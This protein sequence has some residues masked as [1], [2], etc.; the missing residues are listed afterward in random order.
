MTLE[1]KRNDCCVPHRGGGVRSPGI[2]AT[3]LSLVLCHLYLGEGGAERKRENCME[4]TKARME[5]SREEREEMEGRTEGK[6]G[7]SN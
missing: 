7:V 4:E 3:L 1:G 5:K 6:K 2:L